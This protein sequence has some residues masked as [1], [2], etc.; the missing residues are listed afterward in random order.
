MNKLLLSAVAGAV[1]ASPLPGHPRER[2]LAAAVLAA[3][4]GSRLAA[5]QNAP[6]ILLDQSPRAVEYQLS[7]LTNDELVAV[8]RKPD[9]PKYR[10]VYAA[11]LTR[12]GLPRPVRDEAVAALAK[13][14]NANATRV[15]IDALARVPAEDEATGGQLL[16]IL[17][18][19]PADALRAQRNALA[20]AAGAATQPWVLRGAYGGMLIADGDPDPAWQAAV[21]QNHLP[22]LLHSIP[23][24]GAETSALRA[25]LFTPIAAL[26][27]GTPDPATRTAALTALGSTRRD[28]ATFNL[29]AREVLQGTDARARAAAIRALQLI[30]DAA[31]Q[32]DQI[33]PLARAIIALVKDTPPDQRTDPAFADIVPFGERLAA[34]L[35]AESGKAILRDLRGMGIRVVRLTT[36]P[37]QMLF[38][39]K[40]FVVEAG[41]PVQVVLVNPDTMPHNFVLGAPG[42]LREIGT[43][44]AM[45]PLPTDPDVK[46][47]VPDSPLVLQATRLVNGGETD[48]L[49]FKAPSAPGEYSFLCSFPGHYLRMYGVM[50]VVP[51]LEAWEASKTVPMDPMTNKPF[52]SDK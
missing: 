40:W 24:L 11:L 49:N 30:P 33:E 19:Q 18:G 13:L 36:V 32:K 15:L 26:L 27:G 38:D 4:P 25:K 29:L 10:L 7:R 34:A 46:P 31:W 43:T 41:K 37:E 23:S 12:K 45:V 28:T 51:S 21:A 50:L 20:Q 48:R 8:E 52:A 14:D 39:V 1:F 42:S 9:D 44:A 22:D 35:P 17:F 47:Y 16:A 2:P 5:G 3:P 6:R